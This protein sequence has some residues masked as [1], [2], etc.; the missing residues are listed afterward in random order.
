MFKNSQK[1]KKS[2]II[3]LHVFFNFLFTLWHHTQTAVLDESGH[4]IDK[5]V[6]LRELIWNLNLYRFFLRN[7]FVTLLDLS[8]FRPTL[9][10]SLV[11]WL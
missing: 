6:I 7:F 2:I 8:F 9:N 5:K 1:E 4:F 11:K 10:S 3:I